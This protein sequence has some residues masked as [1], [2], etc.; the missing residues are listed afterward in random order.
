MVGVKAA[1]FGK[2]AGELRVGQRI[3]QPDHGNWDGRKLDEMR[4]RVGY[5]GL[6]TV[7][8]NDETGGDN[9]ASSIDFVNAFDQIA[10]GVLL[11]SHRHQSFWIGA[12]DADE[13]CKEICVSHH[14]QKFIIICQID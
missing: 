10:T 14:V 7:E 6:L 12:F 5:F 1:F 2:A 11:L 8:T 13:Q 4:N 9:H 3:K